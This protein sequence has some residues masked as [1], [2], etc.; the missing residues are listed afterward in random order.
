[1]HFTGQ[2]WRPPFEAHNALLQVTSGCMHNKYKFCSLYHGTKFRM[3]PLSEIEEDLLELKNFRLRTNRVFL[4]GANPF[5]LSYIK[6]TEIAKKIKHY[7]PHVESIGCFA[8]ISD[9][10][11]KT[12]EELNELYSIGFNG[13]SIGTETGD[14]KTLVYMNKGY[15]AADIVEQLQ[16]LENTGI[17]YHLTYMNGLAGTGYSERHALESARIFNLAKPLSINIV[18]LTIF[19]ESELHKEVLS[20]IYKPVSETEIL[21][22]LKTFIKNLSIRST[23]NANTVSNTAPF[24]AE[25]PGDKEGVLEALQGIIDRFDEKC[26][27]N[28]RNSILSL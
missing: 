26:L 8:R 18:G 9:I 3:S 25:L 16:K 10:K 7:L 27:L 23:I 17:G 21:C 19:P 15:T 6:L 28:Y 1:M 13:I 24:V 4:T 2:V 20:G 22:E 5:G 14:D 11:S 12:Q